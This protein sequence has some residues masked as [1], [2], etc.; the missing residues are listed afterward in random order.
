MLL[1]EHRLVWESEASRAVSKTVNAV[2]C[3]CITEMTDCAFSLEFCCKNK[4]WLI[5]TCI[6]CAANTELVP[7]NQVG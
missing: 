1:L 4:Q 2:F 5:T 3:F 7:T 6:V